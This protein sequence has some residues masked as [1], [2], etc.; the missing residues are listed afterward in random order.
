M[1]KISWMGLLILCACTNPRG[2]ENGEYYN[3]SYYNEEDNSKNQR[4]EKEQQNGH[5]GKQQ[6]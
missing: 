2:Y 3:P 5:Q 4:H 1:K 6:Q